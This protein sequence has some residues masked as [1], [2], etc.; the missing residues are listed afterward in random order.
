MI[1]PIEDE[2]PDDFRPTNLEM[3]G[4]T[5]CPGCEALT[6]KFKEILEKVSEIT[7]AYNPF[8]NISQKADIIKDLGKTSRWLLEEATEEDGSA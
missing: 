6:A 2:V 3:L 5:C 4:E 7:D 1:D 8:D